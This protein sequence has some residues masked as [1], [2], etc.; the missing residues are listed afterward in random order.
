MTQ[1]TPY[2]LFGL[3]ETYAVD[4]ALLSERHREAMQKVHPDRFADRS[5]AERRV[6]EQ[7]SAL[8]NEAYETL[9]TPVKRAMW[10]AE[11][12][13]AAVEAESNVRMPADF[14]MEQMAWRE[15]LDEAPDEAARAAVVAEV[16]ARR[17]EVE[18]A[19]EEAFDR[20]NDAVKGAALARKLLFLVKFI[21]DAQSAS[22]RGL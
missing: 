9:R 10:L 18:A 1:L 15:A 19:L 22:A 4:E 13:G 12:R 5:A 2:Q 6:A 17:R 21:R 8:I 20:Q 16:D 14:L 7:W 11:R 3:P